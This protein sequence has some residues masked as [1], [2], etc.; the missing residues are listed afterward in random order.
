MLIYCKLRIRVTTVSRW[1]MCLLIHDQSQVIGPW[2][3]DTIS[4]TPLRKFEPPGRTVV[5][6]LSQ[7]W[8]T[9]RFELQLRIAYA[10]PPINLDSELDFRTDHRTATHKDCWHRRSTFTPSTPSAWRRPYSFP[11]YVF[12][13]SAQLFR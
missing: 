7:S 4:H 2:P 6:P 13:A 8:D 3:I 9:S 11:V 10:P 1:Y 5:S 12:T